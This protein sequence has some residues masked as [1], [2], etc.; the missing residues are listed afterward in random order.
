M[1]YLQ[2]LDL[3]AGAGVADIREAYRLQT[4]TWSP[5]RPD[6][7]PRVK[8]A[9]ERHL[10]EIHQAYDWLKVNAEAVRMIAMSVSDARKSPVQMQ[11][12]RYSTTGSVIYFILIGLLVL[13]IVSILVLDPNAWTGPI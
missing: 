11:E 3:D 2:V 8:E 1:E 10:A 5:D 6:Y 9:S 4:R 12:R 7:E 13:G